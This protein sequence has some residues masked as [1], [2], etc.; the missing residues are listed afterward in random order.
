MLELKNIVKHYKTGDSVVEAL[1]GVNI[2]FR[3]SEFVAILG[4]SGCGKTTLL[5]IIGGLDRYTSGDL[6]INSSS[7]K[8]F[9][10]RDW[11]TYRN[12]SVGFVFQSYNLIPHQTV[13][14]NV[15]LA[16]TLSG[17]PKTER[18][19]RA[20]EA[21]E[22]VGLGD[23]LKKKPNQMSGGQMQRVAIARALVN[24]PD[25]LLADEPTG[26]LDS[27]TS[28]QIMEILKKISEDKLIIMVTHNPE[29]AEK[30]ATRTVHLVDG[31]ITNDSN[32]YNA[33]EEEKNKDKRIKKIKNSSMS[34]FTA[35]SLSLKNLFT[36]KAR[37]VLT[38][39][40]GS[41]GI[42]GIA[43]ILS[44]STGVNGYINHVQEETLTSYPI[45]VNKENT[46]MGSMLTAMMDH[47]ENS[48]NNKDGKV[49]ASKVLYEML[50]NFNNSDNTQNDMDG[51]KDFLEQNDN[52]LEEILSGIKYSYDVDLNIYT[53]DDL[54]KISKSD[55]ED[56]MGLLYGE[57]GTSE[58]MSSYYKTM[59][60]WSEI[61]PE[62][63]KGPVSNLVKE[64]YDVLHGHWPEK[65]NEVV[66]V[67][68]KNNE[69]SDLTMYA[70]GLKPAEIIKDEFDKYLDGGTVEAEK[71]SWNYEELCNLDLKIILPSDSFTYN[72]QTDTYTDLRLT[73][74]GLEYLYSDKSTDVKIVG[75][76]KLK[77]GANQMIDGSIAY[78]N[79]LTEH[80]I[81][82]ALESEI[83]KKQIENP[84]KDVITGL[85]FK[86]DEEFTDSEKKERVIEYISTLTTA[87]KAETLI[88]IRGTPEKDV[89]NEKVSAQMEKLKRED[90][91]GLL[92]R[93]VA[94]EMSVNEETLDEYVTK[95]SDEEI[96]DNTRKLLEA[97]FSAQ[98][99]AKVKEQM[100]RLSEK[101]LAK[102][103]DDEDFIED[104]YFHI[105]EV[106]KPETISKS[107]YNDNLKELGFI[108]KESPDTI[109]LYVSSFKNKDKVSDIIEKYNEG[110]PEEKQ[111]TYTD[112]VGLLMSSVTT[113]IS[114]ISYVLMAFVAISLIVSSIMIGIITYISVLERTKEIGILR[115][116]GASKRDISRV[117]NA[118][119]VIIGLASGIMGIGITLLILLP[120]N[121][122]LYY[123][124]NIPELA[125]SL[126]PFAAIILVVISIFLTVI[127]GLF[128]SRLAAKKDPVEALRTE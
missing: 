75:I 79:L 29:L 18:R 65:Y 74:T 101:Q 114:A 56:L 99:L 103:L 11:D 17:V 16:L 96:D 110:K 98:Y 12:H 112:Y 77:P 91:E 19:K 38:A 42:I 83:L 124:T 41:I 35:L 115:A 95:M 44:V 31:K 123:L 10:D 97:Q 126:P 62:N 23:Q 121:A 37:T 100:D 20:V 15:E 108:D 8:E 50:N 14:A 118:E 49:Y 39:F 1:N 120:I 71:E 92:K 24:D 13:L 52:G 122:L 63:D 93:F 45:T 47:K 51:F 28:I 7:T 4:H 87:K 61:L 106:I 94:Q 25:I 107:T 78:T 113:I 104:N 57:M 125:A 32:P 3:K 36:K 102:M 116:I 119:T 128:P 34:F 117:F 5:N 67:I 127:A 40:A 59:E 84:Q 48:K 72:E 6:I 90:K 80:I 27:A 81:D 33:T 30:Y 9:K 76:V 22:K 21:L 43:L 66:L 64:Q 26:A 109:N 55:V 111:I 69:I 88:K 58:M 85:S 2:R 73:D 86:T 53:K 105:Y 82:S 46:D 54:G 89:L 60:I 68:N 70:L